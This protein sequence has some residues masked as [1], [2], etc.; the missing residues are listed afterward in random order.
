M[1]VLLAKK[2]VRFLIAGCFNTALDFLLLNV[3]I[4]AFGLPTLV[5]NSVS[6]LLGIGVSYALNHF[7]V[8]RYPYPI[9]VGTFLQFFAVTGFSSLVLQSLVIYLFELLFKTRFGNS[10]LFLTD[11]AG[12]HVLAIN[13]AKASAVLVGLVWN[14]TFYR[15]VVFRTRANDSDAA[16]D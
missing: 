1:R 10:L 16:G 7:F 9:R 15:F 6:V 11:P 13:I 12:N 2:Q 3:L 4:L 8:F 14:F 5:A